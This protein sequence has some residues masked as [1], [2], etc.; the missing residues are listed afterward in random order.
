MSDR[1]PTNFGPYEH[2][3]KARVSRSR[4]LLRIALQLALVA[5]AVIL[6]G[7]FLFPM[8]GNEA[9][10]SS[11]GLG[12]VDWVGHNGQADDPPPPAH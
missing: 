12:G 10:L 3:Y 8:T 9:A 7:V 5:V 2:E 4:R 1:T 11:D 6:A